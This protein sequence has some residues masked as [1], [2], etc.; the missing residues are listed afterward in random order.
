M[1]RIYAIG[2]ALID[3]IPVQPADSLAKVNAFEKRQE[4]HQL[5]LRSPQPNLVLN[6]ILLEW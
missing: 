5:M 2:E 4:E 3:F 6:H 1:G